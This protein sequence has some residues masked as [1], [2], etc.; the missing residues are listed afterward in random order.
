MSAWQP[1]C[2]FRNCRL[3]PPP[4]KT[5]S[6]SKA[7]GP[8][9]AQ[10]TDTQA[11]ARITEVQFA[12]SGCDL[13][14]E[15][16]VAASFEGK[17]VVYGDPDKTPL[18]KK[19]LID[20]ENRLIAWSEDGKE[21]VNE[22][23]CGNCTGIVD[24]KVS[25]VLPLACAPLFR[26]SK[27]IDM[28]VRLAGQE[29]CRFSLDGESLRAG[30]AW[31]SERQTALAETRAEEKCTSPEGCFITSACCKALGLADDCFEL[32]ALRRYRDDV[33]AHEPGGATRSPLTTPS[34]PRSW[35]GSRAKAG[36]ACLSSSMRATCCRAPS[37][38]RS[39]SMPSPIAST[40]GCFATSPM[41]SRRK[42]CWANG[43]ERRSPRFA[44]IGPLR[45]TR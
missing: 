42:R 22:P 33:L 34:R 32:R 36:N 45:L 25:I 15:V 4:P 12:V 18:P 2:G 20:P 44:A 31:A 19:V 7:F 8:W 10:A 26:E 6:N 16:L 9:K 5:A 17:I 3:Q 11:G 40:D 28:A 41:P 43:I 37:R 1:R 21:A 38:R 24:N 14:I 30:L 23:L 13:R 29:E 35:R 27:S 39:A